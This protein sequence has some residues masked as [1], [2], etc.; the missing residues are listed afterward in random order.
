MFLNKVM[1][2]STTLADLKDSEDKLRKQ[3]KKIIRQKNSD[4]LKRPTHLFMHEKRLTKIVCTLK[5]T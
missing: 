1:K 2:K 3:A 4:A 5:Y